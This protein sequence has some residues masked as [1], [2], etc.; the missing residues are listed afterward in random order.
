MPAQNSQIALDYLGA[1]GRGDAAGAAGCLGPGATI[2]GKGFG[3]FAGACPAEDFVGQM[4]ALNRIA[5]GGLAFVVHS[6]TAEG[7]RV[8]IECEGAA[9]L[10]NGAPYHNQYVMVFTLRDGRLH[11]INEYLCT[12]LAD[13]VLYPLVAGENGEV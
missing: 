10:C 12:K 8:V 1:L 7:E 11:L 5:P 13:E 4:E 3:E 2:V 6:V 9:T